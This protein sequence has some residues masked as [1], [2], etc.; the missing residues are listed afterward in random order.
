MSL[1]VPTPETNVSL[2]L[3][4]FV[5]LHV[6]VLSALSSCGRTGSAAKVSLLIKSILFYM[7]TEIRINNQSLC[8]IGTDVTQRQGKSPCVS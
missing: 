5:D 7:R 1:Q 3:G 6:T 4:C 8:R 2:S